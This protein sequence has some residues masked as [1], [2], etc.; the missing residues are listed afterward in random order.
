MRLRGAADCKV[1]ATFAVAFLVLILVQ[2][3]SGRLKDFRY[4][5]RNISSTLD[6]L[7]AEGH[8]DKRIRPDLGGE[9]LASGASSLEDDLKMLKGKR[10]E[11]H[12]TF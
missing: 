2:A 7:L 4:M 12:P 6:S 3:T 8:Y 10:S 11:S 5:S 9:Q 1:T